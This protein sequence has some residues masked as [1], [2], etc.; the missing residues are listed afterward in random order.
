MGGWEEGGEAYTE[1][2]RIRDK[3]RL[4][5]YTFGEIDWKFFG[6]K[7]IKMKPPGMSL[8]NR[9]RCKKQQYNFVFVLGQF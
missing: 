9:Y 3:F 8:F 5:D 1:Q 7:R 2:L 6:R 4:F